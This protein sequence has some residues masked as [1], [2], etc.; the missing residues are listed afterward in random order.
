MLKEIQN[1]D[2][3][4]DEIDFHPKD[5]LSDFV[6]KGKIVKYVFTIA[7]KKELDKNRS[8]FNKVCQ[9]WTEIFNFMPRWELVNITSHF[10][11]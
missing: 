7:L 10:F 6:Q 3:K 2:K 1:L 5:N 4:L 9:N 11:A 8:S